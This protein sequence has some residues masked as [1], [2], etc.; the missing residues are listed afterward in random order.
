MSTVAQSTSPSQKKYSETDMKKPLKRLAMP[1]PKQHQRGSPST[2][3]PIR[4]SHL[5]THPPSIH[6]PPNYPI[7]PSNHPLTSHVPSPIQFP[8]SNPRPST[9]SP[10]I[11]LCGTCCNS[12]SARSNT[13][14]ANG[15]V[16]C[17]PGPG[18]T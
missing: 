8:T 4:P 14:P 10:Q 15:P 17:P 13:F 6:Q 3:Q 11:L 9:P 7:H 1:S 16:C 12:L 2:H 5:P 18:G